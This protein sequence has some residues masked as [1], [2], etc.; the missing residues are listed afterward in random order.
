MG[1]GDDRKKGFFPKPA[2]FHRS[3]KKAEN[4]LNWLQSGG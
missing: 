2:S 4:D 1:V 3:V